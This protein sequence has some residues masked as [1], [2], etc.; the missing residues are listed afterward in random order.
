MSSVASITP[1]PRTSISSSNICN[2]PLKLTGVGSLMRPM[3]FLIV[4]ELYSGWAKKSAAVNS[5][6]PSWNQ[7]R[8][9][10]LDLLMSHVFRKYFLWALNR[11]HFQIKLF[12]YLFHLWCWRICRGQLFLLVLYLPFTSNKKETLTSNRICQESSWFWLDKT[13]E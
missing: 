2:V 12:Y 13:K 8:Q 11:R 7:W 9:E 4:V 10:N 3:S 6:R 1:R 5:T